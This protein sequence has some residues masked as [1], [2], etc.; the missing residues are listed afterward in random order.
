MRPKGGGGRGR[1]LGRCQIMPPVMGAAAFLMVEY[2]GIPYTEVIKH[3]F[4]PA[5][6]SY[7]ALFYVSH[8]GA[9]KADIRGLP[10]GDEIR[11]TSP[12]VLR[13]HRLG[14]DRPCRGGLLR[15]G[16]DGRRWQATPHRSSSR[17]SCSAATSA[18]CGTRRGI[19][20]SC[21][22][23]TPATPTELPET[24][25]DAEDGPV[26]PAAGGRR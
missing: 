20:P 7:I 15:H 19:S 5:L 13:P 21:T 3:A 6:I 23:T 16:L 10:R 25:P 17:C 12:A 8:L 26:L 24:W 22:W 2:V 18:C 1:G 11:R 4:L 14:P 9:L